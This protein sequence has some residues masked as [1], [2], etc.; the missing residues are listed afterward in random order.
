MQRDYWYTASR[1]PAALEAAASVGRRAAERVL[2]RLHPRR[3]GTRRA[4]VLFVPELARGL[5]GSFIGAISGGA[6]YRKSSFLLDQIGQPVFASRV[7][8]GQ[9]PQLPRAM[10]S[11]AYD[12]EGVA[13]T[14]RELVVDGVLQ[15]YVLGSYSAR[16][17]GLQSTG[18]A[19]GVFNL[20]VQPG[21]KSFDEL[22][23]EM[24]E[25]LVVTELMGQ[26][27][28]LV[29]GDYSRGAAGFWVEDGVLA[30][31]VAEITIAGN[32]REMFKAVQALGNDVD[33]RGNVRSGSVLIEAM[34]IA[35]T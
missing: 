22:V 5:F 24:G 4:P 21:K 3:L 10:G 9:R 35:G 2:Q 12:Q 8:I 33:I 19:G 31:P 17:L 11:A 27:V 32:L 18:N 25:G 29:T 13:T 30:H 34:T 20:V 15:G 7:N 16:R 14:D 6:L 26:G 1:V 23:R 28:N